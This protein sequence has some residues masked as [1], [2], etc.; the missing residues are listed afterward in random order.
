MQELTLSWRNAGQTIAF[1]PTMGALH[2]GHISLVRIA[3]TKADKVV[4]SIFVN[5]TQFGPKEDFSKYPRTLK[6]DSALL[7][8]EKVDAIFLPNSGDMYPDG[9]QSFVVNRGLAGELCGRSRPGHFDGVLTVVCKLFQIVMPQF[10][11][12]GKKDYQ[13]LT[14]I[15]TM[16]K[17]LMMPLSVE[18]CDIV[19]DKDQLA[20]SSRNRNIPPAHLG[21][22]LGLS[23]AL[24]SAHAAFVSGERNP[25]LLKKIAIN[26]LEEQGFL[27]WE[28]SQGDQLPRPLQLDYIEVRSQKDL[29]EFDS[30][31]DAS[32]VILGAV[33][34]HGVRLIDNLELNF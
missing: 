2:E 27:S 4:V 8:R 32:G 33:Y 30:Q 23:K 25:V 21:D 19:R 15:R 11:L 31:V 9:F 6:E 20:L 5:P 26:F 29:R 7:S 16:V 34:C 12:F 3:A 24:L 10:A 14:L 22:A 13:Q 1:V 18:G 28:S 17:D